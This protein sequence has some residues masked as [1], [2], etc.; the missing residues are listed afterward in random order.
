MTN[1]FDKM[2]GRTS[3]GSGSTAK[4]RLQVVLIHDRFNLPPE[5]L[6]EMKEEILAVISKYVA[7]DR[8]SVDIALEQR[9][10]TSSK[11]RADI[12]LTPTRRVADPDEDV[13]DFVTAATLA[14]QEATPKADAPPAEEKQDDAPK[15]EEATDDKKES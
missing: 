7:V 12:P 8:D 1:F 4:D 9:D 13:P 2:L 10:R 5:K 15:A 14:K 6:R 11:I 3:K